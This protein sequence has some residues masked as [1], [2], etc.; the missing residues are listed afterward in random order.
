MTRA[1]FL[2]AVTGSIVLA[3]VIVGVYL[4]LTR[5]WDKDRRA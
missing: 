1:V 5:P 2:W 4:E 3:V